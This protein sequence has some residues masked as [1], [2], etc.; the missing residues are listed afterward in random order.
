MG[1]FRRKEEAPPTVVVHNHIGEKEAAPLFE[2]TPKDAPG[3]EDEAKLEEAL[4]RIRSLTS[5]RGRFVKLMADFGWVTILLA[6]IGIL[7]LPGEWY[8]VVGST[9]LAN[10][11]MFAYTR[12]VYD[13]PTVP[14]VMYDDDGT[15]GVLG[16]WLIPV[17]I[18]DDM[19]KTGLSNTIRT[20]QGNSYMVRS[21]TWADEKKEVPVAAEFSWIHYNELNFAT[22]REIFDEIRNELKVIREQNNR[23]KWLLENMALA[24]ALALVKRWIAIMSHGRYDPMARADEAALRREIAELE[25]QTARHR[26]PQME[27]RALTELSGEEDS[28]T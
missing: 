7:V 5:I 19:A 1:W 12:W 23:Y 3:P 22:K 6:A 2:E 21:L 28:G 27:D 4:R 20:S 16:V 17:E 14:V 24:R 8:L 15:G 10:L 9:V 26:I 18:W 13:P 25:L 11:L